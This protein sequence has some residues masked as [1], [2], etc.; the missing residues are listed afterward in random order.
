MDVLG[1][2]IPVLGRGNGAVW[3]SFAAL[4]CGPRAASDYIALARECH[5]FFVGPLPHLNDDDAN[6]VRRFVMLVDT[7]YDRAAKLVIAAPVAI[8]QLYS[9]NALAFEFRRTRSRLLEMQSD[10][11]L[12]RK[13]RAS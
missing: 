8:E 6:A 5:T 11:Y 3:F 1:R 7:L 2:S 13:L 12:S 9:G 4:C 10:A